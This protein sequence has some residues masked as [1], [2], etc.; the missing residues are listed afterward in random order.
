MNQQP[1]AIPPRWWEPKLTAWFVRASR[2][3]RRRQLEKHQR[4]IRVETR[5]QEHVQRAVSA[6]AGVLITPNHSA[7]YDSNALYVAADSFDQPLYFM[8]A[9]QVFAMSSAWERWAMQRLGCFSIDRESND[10][11]AYRQ[12][13]EILRTAAHPLVVFPEGDIY[14][15]TDRVT[16]FREGA[17]AVALAA[18]RRAT[19]PV[20]VIP[21]G[22]KFWYVEDP[23]D[24]LAQL[25]QQLEQRL[26][27]SPQPKLPLRD[28]ILRF[29]EALLALKE[30][31]YLG[32]N[33]SGGLRDRIGQLAESILSQMESRHHLVAKDRNIPARV[34]ELRKR[35]IA[36]LTS[37]KDAA[38][39]DAKVFESLGNEMADLF[40]V[41]QLFSYP[42]DYLL[43]H[44]SVERLAETLDKFEEDVLLRDYPTVHG[45]RRVS[46]R[47]GE[48]LE[49]NRGGRRQGAVLTERMQSRVQSLLDQLNDDVRPLDSA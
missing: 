40:F 17:A 32:A 24:K 15:V 46:I 49:V 22:I 43:D 27:L 19:R 29:A 11:Q 7:H 4:I 48:P 6:G 41:M 44:P 42:G 21:C 14:H 28:R 18:A 23:T 3:H 34:K 39:P 1:Y 5:G 2:W 25:M 20:L 47:F 10:R 8:T 16:P 31:D 45:P 35:V 33:Q 9:W 30:I 26:L 13:M 36:Q 12:A 38:Q 37:R